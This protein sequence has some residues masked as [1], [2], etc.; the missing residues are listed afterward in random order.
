MHLFVTATDPAVRLFLEKGLVPEGIHVHAMAAGT[1]FPAEHGVLLT[2]VPMPAGELPRGISLIRLVTRQEQMQT[3]CAAGQVMLRAPFSLGAL[4]DALRASGNPPPPGIR[5]LAAGELCLDLDSGKV[6]RG[7]GKLHLHP[8]ER[9]LLE[10]L[11]RQPGR[12]VQ[13]AEIAL[14]CFDYAAPPR[15]G[16]IDVLVSRLRRTLDRDF[17]RPM[18]HT[19]RGV[20]YILQP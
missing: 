16:Q 14:W 18:L 5:S 6:T 19:L 15:P 11:L 9:H 2:D 3:A 1:A 12:T 7:Y 17:D 20:G 4:Y 8:Q 10:R 13:R